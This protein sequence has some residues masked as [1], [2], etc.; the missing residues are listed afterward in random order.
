MFT[1]REETFWLSHSLVSIERELDIKRKNPE[2]IELK[3]IMNSI[4][5][6][7]DRIFKLSNI[8]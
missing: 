8:N 6:K 3:T 1:G 4:T 2:I 5:S 7:R